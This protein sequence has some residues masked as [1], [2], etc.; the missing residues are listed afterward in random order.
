MYEKDYV[1]RIA[2]QAAR[3]SARLLGLKQAGQYAEALALIDQTLQ[4]DIGPRLGLVD[5]LSA[6]ELILMLRSGLALDIE[7]AFFLA[8]L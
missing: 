1:L 7:K 2:S 6:R 5:Q 3:V 8:A 4:E